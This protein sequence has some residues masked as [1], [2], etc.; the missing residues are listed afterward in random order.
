MIRF[1]LFIVLIGFAFNCNSQN[2]AYYSDPEPQNHFYVFDN[3]IT[4][5]IDHRKVVKAKVGKDYLL[6]Q[7]EQGDFMYYHNGETERILGYFPNYITITRNYTVAEIGGLPHYLD[8]GQFKS[9]TLENYM[10]FAVG[11]SIIA[12]VA[13]DDY[14]NIYENGK[15]EEIAGPYLESTFDEE[16]GSFFKVSSNTLAYYDL[17]E[18]LN[19]LYKGE[20]IEIEN[21]VVSDFWVGDNL[22]AYVNDFDELN[23]Y[24]NGSSQTLEDRLPLNVM[25]GNKYVAYINDDNEFYIYYQGMTE[26]IDIN[27][28]KIRVAKDDIIAWADS[29]G[30]FFYW[31]D[32]ETERIE[33]YEPDFVKADLNHIIYTDIN[34]RLKGIYDGEKVKVSEQIVTSFDIYGNVVTYSVNNRD[35]GIYWKGHTY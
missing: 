34:G 35:T 12:F 23:V 9:L 13:H 17:E 28:V 3:G 7:N 2:I 30:D 26:E 1:V 6:Y 31:K 33:R 22:V 24:D 5:K 16:L 29:N 10:P 19:L 25:V 14:L 4:K 21:R 18:K 27:E 15:K 32:G 11:D 20:N 8:G